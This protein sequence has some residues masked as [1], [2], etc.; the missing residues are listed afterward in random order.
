MEIDDLAGADDCMDTFKLEPG[1]SEL[2]TCAQTVV[3]AGKRFRAS[4]IVYKDAGNTNT[5]ESIRRIIELQR[6]PNGKLIVVGQS[7]N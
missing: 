3:K 5:V 6:G 4:M 7:A 2:Y 1:A